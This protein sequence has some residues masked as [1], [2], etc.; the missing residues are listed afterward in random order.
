[1]I[2][3][4][5]QDREQLRKKY[6]QEYKNIFL[7]IGEWNRDRIDEFLFNNDL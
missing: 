6:K 1:M 2:V 3:C 5:T 4:Y 7:D